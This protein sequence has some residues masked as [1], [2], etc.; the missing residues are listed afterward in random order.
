MAYVTPRV[1][2]VSESITAAK[3]NE[4]SSTLNFLASPPACRA[5]KTSAP[6]IN[7]AT[8]TAITFE[9]NRFDNAGI[10]TPNTNAFVAVTAGVWD[11]KG[12]IEFAS[13][14]TGTRGLRATYNNSNVQ[15][16][17]ERPANN[18]VP[19]ELN[20]A[21]PDLKLVIGDVMRLECVQNSGGGLVLQNVTDYSAVA[22]MSWRGFGT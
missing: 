1:W 21:C 14:A 12:N 10:H 17:V 18:G 13:N 15:A 22:S 7:N 11:F 19:S 2:V 5:Y 16:W 20:L 3:L 6:S 4:I 9:Q 8:W